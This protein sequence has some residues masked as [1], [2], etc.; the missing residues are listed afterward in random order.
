MNTRGRKKILLEVNFAYSPAKFLL[1]FSIPTTSNLVAKL[2]SDGLEE[3]EAI[4][5]S[6]FVRFV[7]NYGT[8]IYN[9]WFCKYGY[10]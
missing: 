10:R 9:L 1:G 5:Y 3:I 8:C 6:D 7:M 2:D 4:I